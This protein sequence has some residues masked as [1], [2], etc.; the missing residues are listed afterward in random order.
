MQVSNGGAGACSEL[1]IKAELS[2]INVEINDLRE[3]DPAC[4]T[5]RK[6]DTV[7]ASH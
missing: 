3:F 4:P 6:R 1:K 7:G 5:V 2:E